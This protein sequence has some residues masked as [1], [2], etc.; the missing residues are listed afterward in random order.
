MPELPE[1]ETV[2]R[3]LLPVVAEQLIADCVVYYPRVLPLNTVDEFCTKISSRR[4]VDLQR[5]GKYLL[6]MLDAPE[7]L[8]VHLRMTGQLVYVHEPVGPIP[9]HTSV[10][11]LFN[12]GSELRFIDQR[13][14]GT[15]Y[16][17][18][19]SELDKIHGLASLGPEP[20]TP[21][22]TYAAF[23][24]QLNSPRAI[25]QILL[26]QS[27]IAGLG[28]IY[29]DEALYRAQIHPLRPGKSLS[30][31]E[32]RNLYTAIIA[33]LEEAIAC[34]GTTIR[35]YRTGSG[36]PGNFQNKLRV[37]H[38]TGQPCFVCGALIER[39]KVGG[40]SSHYCPNCQRWEST[41]ED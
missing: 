38:R 33:V 2:R 3:T 35:D 11:F 36:D 15:M 39:I 19:V 27:K 6:F 9:K 14:F 22:F 7:C 10:Q 20:L 13:K 23:A 21:Q 32:I 26:D 30:E 40:R 31:T 1:V 18:P 8:V 28:N 12:D 25:K 34:H 16:L 4:I 37:Y 24:K 17:L 29:C 41:C 5:H